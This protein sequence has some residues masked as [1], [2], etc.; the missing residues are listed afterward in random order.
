MPLLVA[1][2]VGW[3]VVAGW[4]EAEPPVTPKTSVGAA[5]PA[6]SLPPLEAMEA[7]LAD[8]DLRGAVSIVNFWASWC[9][10]CREEMP[11]LDRLQAALGGDGFEVVAVNVDSRDDGRDARFLEETGIHGLARY[12]DRSMGVFNTLKGRALAVGMPTT[13]L[14]DGAGCEL[15][16]MHGPAE[17]DSKDAEALIEAARRAP[18]S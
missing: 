12:A 5:V 8:G 14:V 16:V 4:F 13:L 10:P 3:A 17:W 2:L 1:L 7:G 11:A 15:G 9:A 18:A 6:F